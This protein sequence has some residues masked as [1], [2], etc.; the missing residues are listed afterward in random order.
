[1]D[2]LLELGD[3]RRRSVFVETG[4]RMN[5]SPG[6]IE[7]DYWVC[8]VLSY[9]FKDCSYRN[10]LL[11]KGGTCLSK[12]FH[13]IQRFSEDIDI[14]INWDILPYGQKDPFGE[15]TRTQ[16]K[17]FNDAA[18][19]ETGD[20]VSGEFLAEIRA[21]LEKEWGFAVDIA[22]DPKNP[23]TLRIIY[24]RLFLTPGVNPLILLEAGSLSAKGPVLEEEAVPYVQPYFPHLFPDC[25]YRVRALSPERTFWEKAMILYRET[26]RPLEKE[27]PHRYSRHYYDFYQ[28]SYSPFYPQAIAD[29]EVLR[30]VIVSNETFYPETWMTYTN[31]ESD[32]SLVP[33]EVRRLSLEEDYV[34][35]EAMFYGKRPS[36]VTIYDRLKWIEEDFKK[37]Q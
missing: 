15:R 32:F 18:R 33:P 7:K 26:K 13:L 16:R 22:P 21:G 35:M 3:D 37:R 25:S 20:F 2:K 8:S 10:S 30:S 6:I 34:S 14:S 12:C 28:L 19:K 27:T 1:M 9:L 36:L 17:K 5:L 31:V 29:R 24:P 11:F 23:M 4:K